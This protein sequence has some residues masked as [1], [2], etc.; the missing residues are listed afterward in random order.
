[1]V[2][3]ICY[4]VALVLF[5]AI[6]IT[7]LMSFGASLYREALG[8]ILAPDVRIAPAVAFYAMYPI[9]LMFFAVMPALKEGSIQTAL[10]NG[11]LLGF[12]AYATYDLTNYATL[13]NWALSITVLDVVYGAIVSAV[14]SAIVYALAPTISRL[15][16]G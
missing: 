16:G 2:L 10:L 4:L 7:W 3:L 13:R 12:I 14:V 11:A 5:A 9:G 8:D 1:M 6:D 15:A